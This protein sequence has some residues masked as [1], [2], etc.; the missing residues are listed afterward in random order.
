MMEKLK[1]KTYH[2]LRKTEKYT[3]TDMVYLASG[4]FWLFL[5][6]FLAALIAL[7]V[8]VAFANL[9]PKQTYGEYKYVFSIFGFLSI[10][11]LLGMGTA[12]T[13]AVAQGYE[14]TPVASLKTKITWG[15]AGSLGAICIMLYYL[16]NGNIRLAESF[17]L[18][19][20]F[21][22]F[23]DT[24]GIFNSVLTGKKLFNI[25]TFY[26]IFIQAI[27]ALAITT[28]LF[29]TDNLIVILAS[30][31]LTYTI[32]RLIVFRKVIEKYTDNKKVDASATKYG[33]HLSV[34]EILSVV[35]E[36]INTLL[37]WHFLGAVPVAV[38]SFAKAI[39]AQISS[40]LQ[41]INTLAFPKFAQRDFQS[42]KKPMTYK[43]L[44]MF[45][46]MVIIVITYFITAPYIYT[47]FF[48]QYTESIFYSQIF[49]LTLLFFPQKFIGTVFQAHAHT[50]ALYISSTIV[51]IV[52][53]IL[54]L[55]LIP[56]F[57]IM[58]AL[59][60]EICARAFN[61]LLVSF[62]FVRTHA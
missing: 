51:P 42:I 13:K 9:L 60:A 23:I 36:T 12:T 39:P 43:M 21:L 56:P 49:A 17:G 55:A 15:F 3:K 27:S 37:L 32:M 22:P 26:E 20:I 31:F 52:R 35:A 25:S 34:M 7:G 38:Y 59:V 46:F 30:Y 28:T 40:A 62:L 57:G 54:M 14:G 44:K 24:L 18:V 45:I 61:L 50:K 53:I 6:T 10:S 33:K 58:G 11:T 4:G 48:P 47:V 16:A 41:R 19:A 8:S 5:K 1:N 29:L 2:V